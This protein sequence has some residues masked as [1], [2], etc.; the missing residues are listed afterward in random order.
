MTTAPPFHPRSPL[1][2][3]VA[4]GA[5]APAPPAAV[6]FVVDDDAD[7]RRLC[8]HL[9]AKDGLRVESFEAADAYLDAVSPD[10]PGCLLL[11]LRL[12]G[13]SGLELLERMR[14]IDDR[15]PV[16][17]ISAGA[18]V[19]EV[20]RAVRGGAVD[21]LTK[22]IDPVEL[23]ARCRVAIQIDAERRAADAADADVRR[24]L[25]RLTPRE[26]EVLPLLVSGEPVKRIALQLGISPKT[27]DVHRSRI[28]N[29][30]DCESVVA[31]VHA[32]ARIPAEA[33]VPVAA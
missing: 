16:V 29:K 22:P 1:T 32:A 19:P 33:G 14:D 25:D 27:A 21:F 2:R 7:T 11:D 24:R 23:R 20:M 4:G 15:R 10:L 8:S 6:V 17:M 28:L 9:L 3:H 30:M 13:E 18:E 26:R 5:G 12:G 31:L